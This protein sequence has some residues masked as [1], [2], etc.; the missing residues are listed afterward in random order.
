V[1]G[2]VIA[3]NAIVEFWGCT[4]G[5][6]FTTLSGLSQATGAEVWAPTVQTAPQELGRFFVTRTRQEGEESRAESVY[7]RHSSDVR[8]SEQTRFRDYL[9][10]IYDALAAN[11]EVTT[12]TADDEQRLIYM[13]DLFDRSGGII[14]VMALGTESDVLVRPG[15]GQAWVDLWRS[16]RYRPNPLAE[17]EE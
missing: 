4:I 3:Q 5:Q 14:H 10:Q 16:Y 8:P 1:R 11:F 9:L 7:L 17:T 2:S 12:P 15:E 13:R 6:H